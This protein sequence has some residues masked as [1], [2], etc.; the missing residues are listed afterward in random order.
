MFEAN[1]KIDSGEIYIQ[2]FFKLK[3][4]ELSDE[5]R[6]L[7]AKTTLHMIKKFLDNKKNIKIKQ[8]GKGNFLRRRSPKDSELDINLSIRKQ[9]NLLRV[10]DNKRYPAFF[11]HKNKKYLLKIYKG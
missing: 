4:H 3:G 8:K 1:S 10:V 9:F 7:Q 2:S 6:S 11:I 5:I